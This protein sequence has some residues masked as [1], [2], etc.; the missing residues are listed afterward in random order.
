MAKN[1]IIEDSGSLNF[2][3]E[4]YK[5][6]DQPTIETNEDLC[7]I[8]N[9]P[10][11]ENWV[12]LECKHKF[13]YIP[14]YNDIL[15]HKKT[16]NR[17]E[18]RILKSSEIRCPYC[19]NIQTTLLPN[20][21]MVGVKQVH[22]VNF[23]DELQDNI[24]KIHTADYV[25][26]SCAYVMTNMV[27][28]ENGIKTLKTSCCKN[29][30]VKTLDLDGKTYCFHHKYY[31]VKDHAKME[32][33]KIKEQAKEQAKHVKEQAKEQAKQVK[34]Q[35]KEQAKQAKE[36]SKLEKQQKTKKNTIVQVIEEN[37]IIIGCVEI[38][39][40]GPKKGSQCGCKVKQN[41]L[42]LRHFKG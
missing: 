41:G 34:E 18:R 30:N 38:L 33:L 39:K 37:T 13:N 29:T 22:G 8:T 6:L 27:V 24:Q 23:F 11:T 5:S 35:A 32:K 14:L 4:L 28:S 3:E 2:Y 21:E 15:I 40:S 16:F 9:S 42:C 20:Y 7:L 10:L 17:L 19:R 25:N 36:Q 26:G 31:A 12:Q 1:Y